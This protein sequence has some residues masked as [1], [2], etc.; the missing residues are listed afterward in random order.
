MLETHPIS[1]CSVDPLRSRN[2]GT[3]KLYI[4]L[5]LAGQTL[6]EL[7]KGLT[8][9]LQ[10]GHPLRA[11]GFFFFFCPALQSCIVELADHMAGLWRF[12]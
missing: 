10:N 8:S 12:V 3:K 2:A 11:L 4:V 1:D 7:D 6:S 5:A 9:K